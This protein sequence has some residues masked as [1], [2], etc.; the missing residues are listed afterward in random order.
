MKNWLLGEASEL[1]KRFFFLSLSL[2]LVRSFVSALP[3]PPPPPLGMRGGIYTVNMPPFK[4]SN[5]D[6]ESIIFP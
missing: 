2:S 4:A 3:C 6:S 1:A 5:E